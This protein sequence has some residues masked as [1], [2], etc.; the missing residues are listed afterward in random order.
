M[1]EEEKTENR[2]QNSE[3]GDEPAVAIV[4]V[5]KLVHTAESLEIEVPKDRD[6]YEALLLHELG[7]ARNESAELLNSLLRVTAEFDNFRKRTARDRLENSH[8]A[9]QRVIV[10]LLPIL[11]SF[12]AAL[13]LNA[14]TENE[15]AV[16]EGMRSTHALLLDTLSQDGVKPIEAVG[17]PF[18]PGLHE[19]ISVIPGEGE[20]IV[21]EEARKGYVMGGRVIRPALVIVGHA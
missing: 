1:T 16:L 7:E 18:D 19:A 3:F 17:S 13:T 15:N 21:E 2:V 9:S 4:E 14:V 6:A 5:P 11:D 12:D 20:Q 8:L 10:S